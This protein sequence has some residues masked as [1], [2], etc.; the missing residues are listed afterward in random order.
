MLLEFW[1]P[2]VSTKKKIVN[3]K[4]FRFDKKNLFNFH[5]M[6]FIFEKLYFEFEHPIF[7]SIYPIGR[8]RDL[9]QFHWDPTENPLGL[10]QDYVRT[11]LGPHREHSWDSP[12]LNQDHVGTQL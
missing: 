12:G 6:V 11:W 4:N 8:C 3:K 7:K 5:K 10:G 2:F 9:A 1:A